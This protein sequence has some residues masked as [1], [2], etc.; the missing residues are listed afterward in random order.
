MHVQKGAVGLSRRGFVALALN[1]SGSAV[2]AGT[3]LLVRWED[4]QIRISAPTFHFLTGKVLHQLQDGHSVGMQ[5]QLTLAGNTRSNILRRGL[6]HFVISY[7][8]WEEK[9]AVVPLHSG[10]RK[11]SHLSATAAEAWCFDH[12][13]LSTS[14]IPPESTVWVRLDVRAQSTQEVSSEG[15][16]LDLTS[17]VEL[18]SR[19]TRERQMRW[20]FEAGPMRLASLR[21]NSDPKP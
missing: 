9:F 4:E 2:F 17:L 12:V 5:F 14:G 20:S 11:V 3:P 21:R 6:S 19:S 10:L 7:D 16:P 13:L 15:D 1:V 18:F 8:L